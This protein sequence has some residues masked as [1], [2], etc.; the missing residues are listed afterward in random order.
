[1]G[2][3]H[4]V[5]KAHYRE[6]HY[7]FN[8]YKRGFS[9][10]KR[11]SSRSVVNYCMLSPRLSLPNTGPN[12]STKYTNAIASFI[13][14][15]GTLLQATSAN[16]FIHVSSFPSPESSGVIAPNIDTLYSFAVL[17]L[18]GNDVILGIPA[19]N[20]DRF[21]NYAVYDL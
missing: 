9:R 8:H 18:S 13:Q 14:V 20:D 10:Q 5:K 15:V 19:I 21:W 6:P 1:M 17:D 4:C 3:A 11:L 7:Q 12:L 16:Q 2:Y